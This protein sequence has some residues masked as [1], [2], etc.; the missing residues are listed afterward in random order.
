MHYAPDHSD[1]IVRTLALERAG[2]LRD[3]GPRGYRDPRLLTSP[4]GNGQ[5]SFIAAQMAML[6]GS[7]SPV[8]IPTGLPGGGDIVIEMPEFP[9]PPEYPD[10]SGLESAIQGLS[11]PDPPAPLGVGVPFL[12]NMPNN[13]VRVRGGNLAQQRRFQVLQ[14]QANRLNLP[15]AMLMTMN[16][17]A[18]GPGFGGVPIGGIVM[19]SGAAANVPV[20]WLLCDGT[21]GTPDLTDKF[22]VGAGGDLSVGD[23]GGVKTLDLDH[24]HGNWSW[25][26]AGDDAGAE[27]VKLQADP[28]V[29][30]SP[31]WLGAPGNP[32][33]NHEVD[34]RPPYYALA[35]IKRVA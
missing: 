1:P 20:G 29:S 8:N 21:L 22:I 18:D 35:F 34:N 5:V 9:E 11:I 14:N 28:P 17:P 23:T 19:W 25:F 26:A 16:L 4:L 27:I 24:V 7:L 30:D 33:G 10:Y 12:G 32:D 2:R 13:Q 15:P 6:S 3:Y 31:V